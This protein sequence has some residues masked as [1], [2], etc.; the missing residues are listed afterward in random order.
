VQTD[1]AYA[2]FSDMGAAALVHNDSVQLRPIPWPSF[3]LCSEGHIK[4]LKMLLADQGAE[5]FFV[6]IWDLG[7][8]DAM[9]Q[10]GGKPKLKKGGMLGNV[11]SLSVLEELQLPENHEMQRRSLSPQ[12]SLGWCRVGQVSPACWPCVW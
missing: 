10:L 3:R 9:Y 5:Q 1:Q 12:F 8:I 7:G 6:M 11:T 4:V 2:I